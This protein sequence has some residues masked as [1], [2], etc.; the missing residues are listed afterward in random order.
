M[1]PDSEGGDHFM[2]LRA[3]RLIIILCWAG[4]LELLKRPVGP[5][6]EAEPKRRRSRKDNAAAIYSGSLQ[7]G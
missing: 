2:I 7:L 4:F 1:Q 6:R 5:R 3:I